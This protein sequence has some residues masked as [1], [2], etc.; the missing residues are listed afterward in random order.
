MKQGLSQHTS[1]R[2]ELR[3]NPRLYQAMDMLYMPMMDL[4]Q[5]LK[6]ELLVNP[7]LDLVEEEE[8]EAEDETEPAGAQPQSAASWLLELVQN[9]NRR[10]EVPKRYRKELEGLE[11]LKTLNCAGTQIRKLDP[12]RSL[13]QLESLDC[14]NTRVSKLDP[15]MY[16]SI[17]T[18]KAYN[19]KVSSREVDEF[20]ENNPDAHVVYYR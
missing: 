16:L 6:Q 4:Q 13:H 5:H 19:T 3:V 7:F 17:R 12:L 11:N 9:P 20:R 14:S 10:T 15:V 18:L 2:Q 8:D 1:M